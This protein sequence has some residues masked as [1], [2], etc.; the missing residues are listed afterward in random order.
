MGWKL[1]LRCGQ[2]AL[3]KVLRS[4]ENSVELCLR[5]DLIKATRRENRIGIQTGPWE[6]SEN[7]LISKNWHSRMNVK[8]LN[9]NASLRHDNRF[10]MVFISSFEKTVFTTYRMLAHF[11]FLK[12]LTFSLSNLATRSSAS[13]AALSQIF[14]KTFCCSVPPSKR[15]ICICRTERLLQFE[16]KSLEVGRYKLEFSISS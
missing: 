16:N 10:V 9:S 11:L 1:F 4:P 14:S 7:P 8:I 3:A 13:F 5:V 6:I 15:D 2:E 12:D